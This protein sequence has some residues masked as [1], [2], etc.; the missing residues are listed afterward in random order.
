[1]NGDKIVNLLDLVTV[2]AQFGKPLNPNLDANG[3]GVINIL[4]L[5]LIAAHLGEVIP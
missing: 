2:A 5:V 3:D 4:D 1:V